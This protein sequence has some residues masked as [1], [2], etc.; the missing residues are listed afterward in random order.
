MDKAGLSHRR[1]LAK[2]PEWTHVDLDTFR[3][4]IV[5]LDRPAVLKGLLKD[6]PAVRAGLQSPQALYDYIR[7]RDLGRPTQTFI[8]PPEIKGGF[9][10][11]DDISGMNFERI[12]RP[13]HQTVAHILQ[14]LDDPDP[15]AI[16]AP[17]A[18]AAE[19]FPEF[20]RENSLDILEPS[21]GARLWI[22]NAIT[23]PTHYDLSDGVACVV[24]GRKRFTFFPP[25]QLPNLYVGPL[26]LTPAGQPTSL[27]RVA[28]PDLKR[29]PRFT[30]ALAAAEEAELE[31]G[32]AVFIP[33]LWWH[34]VESLA[35]VNLLVNYWWFDAK[36]GVGSPFAALVMGLLAITDLPA[37]R[38]DIW[39]QIFDHYVFQTEG[40]PV[41]YL[42]AERR[43][44][45]GETNPNLENY[46][47]EGVIRSLVDPLPKPMVEQLLRRVFPG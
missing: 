5:P 22:G 24:A 20:V 28:D 29:F 43:G 9:H 3:T 13:F 45:L 41:P 19:A 31:P 18:T 39:R 44:M 11:R 37:S 30:Q 42:P 36:R 12:G 38:R 6:W 4:E 17:G 32:D 1:P 21:V 10:Y 14:H 16:Y 7:A 2:T 47:R 26:D 15:P 46:M 27:V 34:N 40:D 23:A 25:D 35:P 33:N 8:G